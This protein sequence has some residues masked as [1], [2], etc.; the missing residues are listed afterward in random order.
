MEVIYRF[1]AAHMHVYKAI[2]LLCCLIHRAISVFMNYEDTTLN[3]ANGLVVC[4]RNRNRWNFYYA[5]KSEA[6]R[7][8]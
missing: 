8:T 1:Q 7:G 2:D 4:N 3:Q 5:S 6:T